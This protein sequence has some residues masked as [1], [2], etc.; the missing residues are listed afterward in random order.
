V[1]L[2]TCTCTWLAGCSGWAVPGSLSF[3]LL[4]SSGKASLVFPTEHGVC[5]LIAEEGNGWSLSVRHSNVPSD[6]QVSGNPPL[7]P[8]DKLPG[9]CQHPEGQGQPSLAD[10]AT[11]SILP[12]FPPTTFCLPEG[13]RGATSPA[14]EWT[15]AISPLAFPTTGLEVSCLR[16]S[17]SA[18]C[19]ISGFPFPLLCL[20][21]TF[22][23]CHASLFKRESLSISTVSA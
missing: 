20:L 21:S 2:A 18:Y 17:V 19:Q 11:L 9:F 6:T 5:P 1:G 15:L 13:S 4:C 8:Q 7:P 14:S 3:R 23:S 10:P 22:I 16:T 12:P